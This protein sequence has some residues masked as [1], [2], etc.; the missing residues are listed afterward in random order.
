M[1]NI[2]NRPIFTLTVSEFRKEFGGGTNKQE[3]P[4]VQDEQFVYGYAG[5]AKLFNC[6]KPTF[7]RILKSGR[8]APAVKQIGKKII[9]DKMMALSLIAKPQGG[10]K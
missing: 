2:D 5:G 8:I 4:Q 10:R 9:I 1:E 7:Y 3:V 6:S